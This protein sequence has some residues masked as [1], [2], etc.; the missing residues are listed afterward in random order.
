MFEPT[1]LHTIITGL[2]VAVST[3]LLQAWITRRD[4]KR[5]DKASETATLFAEKEARKSQDIIDLKN[6]Y[7]KNVDIITGQ[8]EKIQTEAALRSGKLSDKL[9]NLTI[10]IGT[11][12]VD[13][14]K[15]VDLATCENKEREMY[16]VIRQDDH[17]HATV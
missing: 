8:L 17:S 2:I 9:D 15:K 13:V 12:K 16:R 4:K 6:L 7:E 3:L 10:C 11:V 5:D 1:T 14:A